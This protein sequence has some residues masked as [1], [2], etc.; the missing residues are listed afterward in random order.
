MYLTL[1]TKLVAEGIEC[2]CDHV[3]KVG[4]IT[5]DGEKRTW[6]VRAYVFPQ[7][8]Y[9]GEFESLNAAQAY[10]LALAYEMVEGEEKHKRSLASRTEA[11]TLTRVGQ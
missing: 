10:A 8:E 6:R 11:L 1:K 2:S 5:R 3:G 7:W 4:I 9:N